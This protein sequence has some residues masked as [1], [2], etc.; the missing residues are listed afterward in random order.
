MEKTA[1][2]IIY[3]DGNIPNALNLKEGYI[4]IKRTKCIGGNINTYYTI[5]GG[6]V[7]AGE[8]TEIAALREIKEELSID[9]EIVDT[10]MN[11]YNSHLIRDEVF[12]VGKYKSGLLQNGDGPEFTNPDI[13]KYGTYEIVCVSKDEIKDINLV[14]LEVKMEILKNVER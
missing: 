10:L 13:D 1:R 2:V 4:C 11:L 5:P 14:P 6:H 9:I 12:Y 8:T 3:N 7:E